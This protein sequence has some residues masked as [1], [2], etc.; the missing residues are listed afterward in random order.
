MKRAL[1]RRNEPS[2]EMNG[3]GT[4]RVSCRLLSSSAVRY[5][6]RHV[7]HPSSSPPEGT[8][9]GS[10]RRFLPIDGYFLSQENRIKWQSKEG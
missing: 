4:D 10:D 1:A 9:Y 3:E 8:T 2:H 6:V 5:A 7:P